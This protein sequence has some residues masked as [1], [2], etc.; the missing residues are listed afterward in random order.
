MVSSNES[1][2]YLLQFLSYPHIVLQQLE[3]FKYGYGDFH[4]VPGATTHYKFMKDRVGVMRIKTLQEETFNS[5]KIFLD[6]TTYSYFRVTVDMNALDMTDGDEFCLEVSGN[7]GV[8]WSDLSCINDHQRFAVDVWYSTKFDFKGYLGQETLMLRFRN[9]GDV[10]LDKVNV[11]G[12]D[13]FGLD[14]T[15]A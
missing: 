10:L 5:D 13:S 6:S 12:W 14:Q 8:T 7:S 2:S 9:T 4:S 3:D 1:M 11:Y 15:E